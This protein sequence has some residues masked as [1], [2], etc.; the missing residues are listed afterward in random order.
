MREKYELRTGS[1]VTCE[2]CLSEE[3]ALY[4]VRSEVMRKRVCES[5]AEAARKLRLSVTPIYTYLHRRAA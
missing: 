3:D 4:I 1:L 5:C 2:R